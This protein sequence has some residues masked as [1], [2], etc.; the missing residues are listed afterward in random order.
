[1]DFCG[2]DGRLSSPPGIMQQ[3]RRSYSGNA[4]APYLPHPPRREPRMLGSVCEEEGG[5]QLFGVR[6][7]GL[8]A[9]TGLKLLL[10]A[11]FLAGVLLLEFLLYRLAGLVLGERRGH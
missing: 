9:H 10:T 6:L 4:S 5:M 7:I 3:P 8:D 1:M 11:I 2:V